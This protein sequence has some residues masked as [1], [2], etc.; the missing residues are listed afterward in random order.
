MITINID[1][2]C[3]GNPGPMGI[4][5]VIRKDGKT[6]LELSEFLG[7][8]TNNIAEYTA[9]VR[10]LEETRKIIEKEGE[11]DEI[12]LV[13]SDSQLLVNQLKGIYKVKAPHLKELNRKVVALC[14]QLNVKFE[15]V[16]REENEWADRLSK[17]AITN[18]SKA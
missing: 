8:G 17:E 4:G 7:N 18:Q 13:R 10:A 14:M 16:P 6:I 15:H 3:F 5:V 12:I 2:A 1:G 11:K 9:A